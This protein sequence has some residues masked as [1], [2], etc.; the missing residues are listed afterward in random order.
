M[1][2]VAVIF[3]EN[4]RSL[5][6]ELCHAEM[7][8]FIAYHERSRHCVNYLI[9]IL[10]NWVNVKPQLPI[11]CRQY[12][13]S[14]VCWLGNRP[15]GGPFDCKTWEMFISAMHP[16][17]IFSHFS[18]NVLVRHLDGKSG[19]RVSGSEMCRTDP[20]DRLRQQQASSSFLIYGL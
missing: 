14:T 16:S 10:C 4:L 3:Y 8:N 1:V 7:Y 15:L 12:D 19:W 9:N 2:C 13:T 11:S 5:L 17:S 20:N 6:Y 18:V